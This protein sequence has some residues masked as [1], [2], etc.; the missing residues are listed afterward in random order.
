MS[1]IC[2]KGYNWNIGGDILM[3][4]G[5]N[6]SNRAYLIRTWWD[7]NPQNTLQPLCKGC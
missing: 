3:K 5:E 1:F 6:E 2:K 4:R 7:L